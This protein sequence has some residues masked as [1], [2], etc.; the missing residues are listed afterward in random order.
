LAQCD[1]WRSGVHV[2]SAQKHGYRAVH[3]LEQQCASYDAALMRLAGVCIFGSMLRALDCL[4]GSMMSVSSYS[5]GNGVVAQY[6]AI[7]ARNFEYQ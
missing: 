2:A 5:V 6:D 7:P 4:A 1:D 3:T